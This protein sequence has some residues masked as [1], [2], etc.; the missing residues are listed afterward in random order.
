MLHEL[1]PRLGLML[2]AVAVIAHKDS[3]PPPVSADVKRLSAIARELCDIGGAIF[4]VQTDRRNKPLLVHIERTDVTDEQKG[5]FDDATYKTD[6]N[7]GIA[8]VAATSRQGKYRLD[9][10]ND[11]GET[12]QPIT[13]ADLTTKK[14]TQL[15]K[16]PENSCVFTV[17]ISP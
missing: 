11:G 15:F 1:A 2:V 9:Y 16:F 7:T 3:K 5:P 14:Y 17:G 10:S 8:V 4:I 13:T 6:P 12:F